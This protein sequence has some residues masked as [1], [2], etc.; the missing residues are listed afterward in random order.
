VYQF[1]HARGVVE[2]IDIDSAQLAEAL[3]G[4]RARIIIT[5]LQ[6]FPFVLDKVEALPARNYA[7]VIDEAHSSQTGDTAKEMKKVLGTGRTPPGEPSDDEMLTEPIDPVEEALAAEV[8]ARGDQANLSFFAFTAT[9]KGRTLELFGHYNPA[10]G[11]HEPFHLYSMRQTIEEGF[12]LDVLAGYVT[13]DMFFEIA[14]KVQEDPE[15][16]PG[17]ASSALTRFVQV[18][19]HVLAQKAQII[20]EHFRERVAQEIG[21]QAKAMVVTS[22]RKHAVRMTNAL[23][24]YVDEHGY[25]RIGILVAFSGTVTDEGVD[26]TEPKMNRLPESQTPGCSRP[27]SGGSLSSPTSTRPASTSRCCTRCTSTSR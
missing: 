13:W 18:H 6:K 22:S 11:R 12:I 19:P 3:A 4:Q 17:K 14:K 23:R 8:A 2:R 24:R 27:S 5:T 16:D 25:D 15:Y 26:Y 20:I 21:G 7:V 10:A 9:P 1:E